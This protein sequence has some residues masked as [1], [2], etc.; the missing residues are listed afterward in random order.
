M[1]TGHKDL[2]DRMDLSDLDSLKA[3]LSKPFK[4]DELANCIGQHWPEALV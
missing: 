2:L 3:I 1:I 4:I